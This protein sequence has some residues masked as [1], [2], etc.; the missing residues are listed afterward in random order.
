MPFGEENDHA[1]R[2]SDCAAGDT[3]QDEAKQGP[4]DACAHQNESKRNRNV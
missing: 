3:S 2:C 1:N 4:E